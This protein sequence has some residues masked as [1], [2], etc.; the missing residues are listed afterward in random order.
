M[1]KL[2]I[3]LLAF[4][5]V[6]MLTAC[7]SGI[8]VTY[9]LEDGEIYE[10][11]TLEEPGQ[12]PGQPLPSEEGKHFLGWFES[13]D[14]TEENR[15]NFKSRV[16]EDMTL[17]GAF[18][19]NGSA[20]PIT[21][22]LELDPSDYEGKSFDTHGIQ[23]VSLRRC[24]DGDTAHFTGVG[25]VRYLNIDTPESTGVIE[26]WGLESSDVMCEW[27]TDADTIVVES[28][29]NPEVGKYGNYG[30]VLGY[31]WAD[32]RLTNLE[33]VEMGY[34]PISGASLSKYA[35]YFQLANHNARNLG[36]KLHGEEDP[37]FDPTRIHTT[38][39]LLNEN[40]EDYHG[41]FVNFEGWVESNEGNYLTINEREDFTGES[42]T[43]YKAHRE[44]AW[45]TEGYMIRIEG[46]YF[47][48]G[49]ELVNLPEADVTGLVWD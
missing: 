23:E 24:I 18:S 39:G 7:D 14:Y 38:I 40:P 35:E 26:P 19:D 42:V 32:G 1:K 20:T 44:S 12:L 4:A 6:G 37:S 13:E 29:P 2:W 25:S 46:L 45:F 22:M 28:E 9:Q 5:F 27:L 47:R 8:E 21:D 48:E 36:L 34:S 11:H 10:T 33:M 41:R 16:T 30:R 49:G 17:Y 15:F 3:T 43:I 31:V